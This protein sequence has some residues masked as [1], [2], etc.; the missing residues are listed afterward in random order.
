MTWSKVYTSTVPV[1][2]FDSDGGTSLLGTLDEFFDTWLPS[3]GW[4][5]HVG[6]SRPSNV[7]G[8]YHWWMDKAIQCLDGSYYN[9]RVEFVLDPS[10]AENFGWKTWASGVAAD[11]SHNNPAI[12][13]N[14][15]TVAIEGSWEMWTSDQDTDSFLIVAKGNPRTLIAY[16][17]PTG[18]IIKNRGNGTTQPMKV[19]P[20]I[21]SDGASAGNWHSNASRYGHHPAIRPYSPSS[22]NHLGQVIKFNAQFCNVGTGTTMEPGFVTSTNDCAMLYQAE[23]VDE[24]DNIG[25]LQVGTEYF[26][27]VGL[28]GSA[29]LFSTG[30]TDPGY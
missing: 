30:T 13:S 22:I 19:M 7:T 21:P 11:T 20:C 25:T 28:S 27:R 26:I 3:R 2:D 24:L 17:P 29:L 1:N 9:H 15:L 4:T 18:S 6:V 16:M 5:T 23:D 10:T 12:T 8:Y 14:A